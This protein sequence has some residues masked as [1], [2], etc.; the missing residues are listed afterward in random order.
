MDKD[1]LSKLYNRIHECHI[2]PEMD[3]EKALRNIDAVDPRTDVFIIS[4]ALAESQ[5]RKSGVNFFKANGALGDTGEELEKFLNQFN[6]TAYPPTPIILP[7]GSKIPACKEGSIPVYNTEVAQCFP[8]RKKSGNKIKNEII[9]C[10][11]KGFLKEELRI[12]QPKLIILQGKNSRDTFYKYYLKLSHPNSLVDHIK[13]I[14]DSKILPSFN[15][16]EY[17]VRVVP[18]IHFSGNARGHWVNIDKV[19]LAALIAQALN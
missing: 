12:I 17:N 16:E 19:R 11:E 4:E 6:R 8:G 3:K 5:L 18:I 2:C 7:N 15:V 13:E 10:Q 9:N 14:M 1:V